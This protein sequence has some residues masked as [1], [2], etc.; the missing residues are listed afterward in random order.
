MELEF[1]HSYVTSLLACAVNLKHEGKTFQALKFISQQQVSSIFN[2]TSYRPTTYWNCLWL[3]QVSLPI[4]A[5]HIQCD[6]ITLRAFINQ[7]TFPF[8]PF[9]RNS[10]Q[11]VIQEQLAAWCSIQNREPGVKLSKSIWITYQQ[12]VW[13]LRASTVR[14]L[15]NATE[16]CTSCPISNYTGLNLIS[17]V[18]EHWEDSICQCMFGY[19]MAH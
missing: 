15:V 8:I 18:F 3:P 11:S 12:H 2:I 13:T 19:W 1:P 9:R 5:G 6:M 16:S 17:Y 4:F 10:K 14:I 7:I